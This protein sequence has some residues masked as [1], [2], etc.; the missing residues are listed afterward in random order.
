MERTGR[1]VLKVLPVDQVASAP[2]ARSEERA[3]TRL[4]A[5]TE[6]QALLP[7]TARPEEPVQMATM[8]TRV[9][10]VRTAVLELM[11]QWVPQE[12]LVQMAAMVQTVPMAARVAR[13]FRSEPD[14][15]SRTIQL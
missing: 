14:R 5:P 3:P 11:V 13:A 2:R 6:P 1:Q 4:T 7:R 8:A 10:M 12:E 9:R 15:T